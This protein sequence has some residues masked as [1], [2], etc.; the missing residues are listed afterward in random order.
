MK[1]TK[2]E[3]KKIYQYAMSMNR[4]ENKLI[5]NAISAIELDMAKGFAISLTQKNIVDYAYNQQ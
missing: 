2:K 4:I 3:I 5:L 1:L